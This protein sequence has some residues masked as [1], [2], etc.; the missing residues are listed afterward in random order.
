MKEATLCYL[1]RGNQICLG[2]KK[3]GFGEG[4]YAGFGGKV[5][6]DESIEA[7]VKREGREEFGIDATGLE[8]VG[9]IVFDSMEDQGW[10]MMVHVY[11]CREW[12]G[13]P[14][15]SEEM[16]PQWFEQTQLPLSEMWPD[17]AVFIPI[18]LSGKRIK[19][20]FKIK[21]NGT[22]VSQRLQF[23]DQILA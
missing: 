11:L 23:T 20:E 17:N 4:K 8:K 15:E 5:E 19:A 2:M 12:E 18:I 6:K 9:E 13:E 3:R 7:S 1:I 16:R 14:T 22:S 21:K 10:E